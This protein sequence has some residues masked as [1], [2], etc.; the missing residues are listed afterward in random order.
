MNKKM[1][2][3]RDQQRET[4]QIST[5]PAHREEPERPRPKLNPRLVFADPRVFFHELLMEQSEQQ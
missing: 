3:Q 2:Q 1:T 4:A 5:Q